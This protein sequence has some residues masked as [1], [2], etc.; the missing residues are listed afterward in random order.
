MVVTKKARIN[1]TFEKA[2]AGLLAQLARQE[3]KSVAQIVRELTMGGSRTTGRY[4]SVQT[5]RQN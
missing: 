2:N 1:V 5:C 3:K 4:V